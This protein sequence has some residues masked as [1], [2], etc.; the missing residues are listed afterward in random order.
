[1]EEAKKMK[2]DRCELRNDRK[3]LCSLCWLVAFVADP[4]NLLGLDECVG[5][6]RKLLVGNR[7][8]T[9]Y[10]SSSA[11]LFFHRPSIFSLEIVERAY[12]NK[13]A[14]DLHCNKKNVF[15]QATHLFVS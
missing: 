11:S 13:T 10:Y 9:S 14:D 6:Q 2:C 5:R 4:L 8:K 1:M 7:E 3:R 12:E 15:G